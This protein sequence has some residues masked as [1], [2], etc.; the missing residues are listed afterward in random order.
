MTLRRFLS[1]VKK[2]SRERASGRLW[3]NAGLFERREKNEVKKQREHSI[4]FS[5]VAATSCRASEP[6]SLSHSPSLLF[7]LSSLRFSMASI[8]QQQ[9]TLC[10]SNLRL[11]EYRSRLS[12]RA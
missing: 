5:N 3:A 4:F 11:S 6:I 9:R 1:K 7:F 8:Q 2:Q 10:E 12:E